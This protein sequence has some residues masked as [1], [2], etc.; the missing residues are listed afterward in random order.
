[1]RFLSVSLKNYRNIGSAGIEFDPGLNV[2]YGKN[3][4]GK[5]NLI[6]ALAY[7]PSCRSFRQVRDRDVIRLGCED[8]VISAVYERGG[9]TRSAEIGLFRG[10]RR[11]LLLDGARCGG[12]AEFSGSINCVLF[13][14]DDLYLI[15]GE[16]AERRRFLVAAISQQKPAYI[17]AASDYNKALSEA[18]RLIKNW[19]E[20]TKS[21]RDS[22]GSWFYQLAE[23]GGYISE[24]RDKYIRLLSERLFGF[25]LD[26]SG[27]EKAECVYITACG[28]GDRKDRC[29]TIYNKLT[30]NLEKQ[31]AAGTVLYG[32]QRDDVGF[33]VD[34]K[35]LRQFGSQGQQRSAVLSAKLAEGEIIKQ[36]AGE[37]PVFLFDDVLS[38]LDCDRKDFL[39][40]R[41]SGKQI[42]I[43]CCDEREFSDSDGKFIRAENGAFYI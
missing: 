18:S 27:G 39:L 16:P 33:F 1:M 35:D 34:G 10:A 2:I 17:R 23:K 14:P 22:I 15:K 37:Y 11:R 6:E 36:T 32:V 5:T 20:Q 30:E 31:I 8:A 25:Y 4:Q 43:T 7:I 9:R 38:E 42:M 26:M 19:E 3:A 29:E 41:L 12:A 21:A 28:E 13:S 24:V 40:R